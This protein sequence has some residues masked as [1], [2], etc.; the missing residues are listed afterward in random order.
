MYCYINGNQLNEYIIEVAATSA[1]SVTPLP[2]MAGKHPGI[3]FDWEKLAA[4][5]NWARQTAANSDTTS[6]RSFALSR[7]H[8]DP[9]G[10]R[11]CVFI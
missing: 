5:A 3:E 8:T 2:H 6:D 7:L 10:L 11:Q 1:T 4:L 9:L